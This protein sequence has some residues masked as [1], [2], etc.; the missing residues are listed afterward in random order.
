[1]REACRRNVRMAVR[2]S[3]GVVFPCVCRDGCCNGKHAVVRIE[4]KTFK[5]EWDGGRKRQDEVTICLGRKPLTPPKPRVS[6]ASRRPLNSSQTHL[7]NL[8]GSEVGWF[9]EGNSNIST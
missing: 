9:G 5:K 4:K 7:S 3:H 1:M 8:N 6:A 2:D